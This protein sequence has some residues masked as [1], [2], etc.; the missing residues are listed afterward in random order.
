[1]EVSEPIKNEG[2]SEASIVK[3]RGA[4]GR[5][6]GV[7]PTAVFKWKKKPGFPI[8]QDG[9]YDLNKIALWRAERTVTEA[10]DLL[11]AT[12]EGEDPKELE[13]IREG[14]GR[15]RSMVESYKI[16]RA[17]VFA[18][19]EAKLLSLAER[20][21]KGISDNK[22]K[23]MNIKDRVKAL[24]DIISSVTGL[25]TS[26]RLEKGESTEN[27]AV[28]ISAIKDLKRRKAAEESNKAAT[29]G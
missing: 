25:Y 2:Q 28:I 24:K 16:E 1:M 21:L 19:T 29:T 20:L 9:T 5:Y 3:S 14:L 10:V 26:E 22:I 7:S 17:D 15:F 12:A 18:G 6:F 13:D 4:V 27:V 23:K 11:P 8:E